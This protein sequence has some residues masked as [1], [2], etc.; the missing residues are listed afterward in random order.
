MKF[1]LVWAIVSV[2]FE[3]IAI[4]V[5]ALLVLP[6]FDINIPVIVLV[7]I[8]VGWLA[9]SS[10]LFIAGNRA[11]QRKPVNEPEAIIGKK[12]VA[13]EGLSPSG[14]VKINGELWGAESAENIAIGEEVIVT[15][16]SGIKLTV[17][18]Y[19]VPGDKIE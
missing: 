2:V 16:Y 8:M 14:L 5:I 12:G 1:R 17:T 19:D 3:E 11:L 4:L 10:F 7:L 13:V 9:L 18:R 15:G 6:R